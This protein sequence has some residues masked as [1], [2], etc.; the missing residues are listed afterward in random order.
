MKRFLYELSE[1]WKIAVAQMNGPARVRG[2]VAF[3][4]DQNDRVAAI[5]QIFEQ[6]HDLF[7]CF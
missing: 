1:S 3:M 5:I 6:S 2:D 4:R 7:A